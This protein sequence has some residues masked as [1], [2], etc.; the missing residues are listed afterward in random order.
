M[1][2]KHQIWKE[3]LMQILPWQKIILTI[4]SGISGC[5]SNLANDLGSSRHGLIQVEG[6]MES[7]ITNLT[8]GMSNIGGVLDDQVNNNVQ[9]ITRHYHL[10]VF[11]R[12]D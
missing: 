11:L 4:L 5:Q 2:K 9:G 10:L 12:A 8:G 7:V 1:D 6:K 3:D